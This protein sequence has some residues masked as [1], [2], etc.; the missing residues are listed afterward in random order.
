MDA[1]YSGGKGIH[2]KQGTNDFCTARGMD[3]TG[4]A[5]LCWEGFLLSEAGESRW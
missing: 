5:S 4:A 1:S 3:V 2:P